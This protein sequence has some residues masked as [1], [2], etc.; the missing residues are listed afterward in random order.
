MTGEKL[1]VTVSLTVG[2]L[3]TYRSSVFWKSMRYVDLKSTRMLK[4]DS[5]KRERRLAG[6]LSLLAR[7]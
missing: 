5:V 6:A 2:V 3:N 4:S 7:L 1:A